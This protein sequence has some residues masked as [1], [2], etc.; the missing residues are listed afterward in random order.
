MRRK[1]RKAKGKRRLRQLA[2]DNYLSTPDVEKLRAALAKTPSNARNAKKR[3]IVDVLINTG[4]RAEEMQELEIKD[5]PHRRRDKTL[6]IRHG[7]GNIERAVEVPASL[8]ER[9]SRYCLVH[10]KGSRKN[11]P[12]VKSEQGGIISY[13]AIYY[14]VK[15]FGIAAGVYDL[16]PHKLRHTYATY[17]YNRFNDLR[18]V[19]EQLGH[20][21][22]RVT[23]NYVGVLGI[24]RGK[25]LEHIFDHIA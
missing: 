8:I 4:I 18:F 13:S 2:A 7:K 23:E 21:C 20:S 6:L 11:S 15:S 12:F 5:L 10:R 25:E 3:I 9:V 1:K 17:V 16:R 19:Q 14:H 24:D 22:S